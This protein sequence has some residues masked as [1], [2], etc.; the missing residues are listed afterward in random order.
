MDLFKKYSKKSY[1]ENIRCYTDCKKNNDN[2]KGKIENECLNYLRQL[3]T[4]SD[5]DTE[6]AK[7]MVKDLNKLDNIDCEASE[8]LSCEECYKAIK[9][10]E[11]GKSPGLD[12]LPAEF[13]KLF[14]P[15]IG[16]TLVR[17]LNKEK[18]L[19]DSQKVSI[20]TLICKDNTKASNL[21]NWRP[22]SLLNVDYKIVSKSLANKVKKVA[23]NV[24]G[25][26]QSAAINNQ[27][28]F[29]TLQ[30]IRNIKDYCQERG[31]PCVL[32]SFDQTK[33]FDR[34]DQN[35]VIKVM[36]KK[37]FLNPD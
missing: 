16:P 25:I 17:I 9:E 24:I 34:M 29:G 27:S 28:I 22:I 6:A 15:L 11:D 30:L 13:Y 4:Q 33:A 18:E 3:Y 14:F 12:G 7:Q 32:L 5:L 31:I 21:D 19:A 36:K 23:E 26:E 10:V 8:D 37:R 1:K 2:T 35:Y 20:I